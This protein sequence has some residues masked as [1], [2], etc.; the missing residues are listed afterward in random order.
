MRKLF[1]SMAAAAALL[2]T[3]ARA[4]VTDCQE[5][6]SVPVTIT[7]QG[8]HCFKSDKVSSA[9][10]GNLIEIQ[11]NNVTIDMNGFKLG[12]S[13]AGAGTQAFGIL[14]SNRKNITIR[15]GTI[16]GFRIGVFLGQGTSSGHLV[17]DLL[18]DQNRENGVIVQ[19]SGN[20]IRNNRVVNTGPGDLGTGAS[21]IV[22][23]NASN[24]VVADN[25]V[26]GTSETFTAFG[27]HVQ[28][29]TLIEV[30][31]NTILDT[32][33]A[34]V[35]LGIDIQN[36]TDVTVI[37]NFLLDTAGTGTTGV[38]T[39]ATTSGINCIDNTIAG[40]ATALSGCD[41]EAGNNLVP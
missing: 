38:G 16:R 21:G 34:S 6:L 9:T 40:F 5:I 26:S 2:T 14:A 7:T 10:S 17:E 25:V 11:A 31:G 37:G 19:G 18:L 8:V 24:S 28:S 33:D 13:G 30:R 23:Q 36:S 35:T 32:K 22:V 1:L 15:N 4:E 39:F 27:I 12:G 29:A 41:F 20:V 3:S